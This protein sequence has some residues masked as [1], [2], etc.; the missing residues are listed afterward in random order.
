[1]DIKYMFREPRWSNIWIPHK[2]TC[3]CCYLFI[4]VVMMKKDPI[5]CQLLVGLLTPPATPCILA[6]AQAP[7]KSTLPQSLVEIIGNNLFGLKVLFV[8]WKKKKCSFNCCLFKD[9]LFAAYVYNLNIPKR[10][11]HL[12]WNIFIRRFSFWKEAG[13]GSQPAIVSV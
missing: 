6:T 4:F 12:I 8:L 13:A 11:L 2:S 5:Y 9:I 7:P 1:M 3:S 10:N